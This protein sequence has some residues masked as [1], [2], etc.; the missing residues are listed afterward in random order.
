M[1]NAAVYRGYDQQRLDAQYNNRA[2]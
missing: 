1:N 2:R